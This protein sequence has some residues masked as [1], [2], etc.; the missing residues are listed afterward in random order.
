MPPAEGAGDGRNDEIRRQYLINGEPVRRT[1]LLARTGAFK[2]MASPAGFEPATD[3]LEG[4]CSI[5]LS[6]GPGSEGG[7]P[8]CRR[9]INAS[10]GRGG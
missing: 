4:Y 2:E 3:S 6:Y 5:Q 7:A 8:A 10:T 9:Q 1:Y